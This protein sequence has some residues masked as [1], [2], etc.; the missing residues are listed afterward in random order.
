MLFLN[1][2]VREYVAVQSNG[3]VLAY[4]D[5]QMQELERLGVIVSAHKRLFRVAKIPGVD[6]WSRFADH[7]ETLFGHYVISSDIKSVADLTQL[8][9]ADLLMQS[10]HD[11]IRRYA[12]HNEVSGWLRS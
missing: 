11:E 7:L 3:E 5:L 6:S 8:I 1:A 10:V 9:I 12:L 4:E 2:R